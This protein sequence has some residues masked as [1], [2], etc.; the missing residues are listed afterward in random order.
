MALDIA[1]CTRKTRESQA[2]FSCPIWTVWFGSSVNVYFTSYHAGQ[3]ESALRGN[4]TDFLSI[5]GRD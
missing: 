5:F 2:Q 3:F 1:E 4:R